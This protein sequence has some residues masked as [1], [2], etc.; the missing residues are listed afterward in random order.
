MTK[1]TN[2]PHGV[3]SRLFDLDDIC[4]QI[5]KDLSRG[6]PHHNRSEV[7]YPYAHQWARSYCGLNRIRSVSRLNY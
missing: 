3:T 4:A 2:S 1:R 6:R 7:E 5:A